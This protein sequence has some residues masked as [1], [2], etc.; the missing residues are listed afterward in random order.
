MPRAASLCGTAF[1][2]GELVL[3]VRSLF[4]QHVPSK[5]RSRGGT[6]PSAEDAVAPVPLPFAFEEHKAKVTAVFT[7]EDLGR[8]FEIDEGGRVFVDRKEREVDWEAAGGRP[9]TLLSGVLHSCEA[10]GVKGHVTYANGQGRVQGKFRNPPASSCWA[11]RATSLRAVELTVAEG[12]PPSFGKLGKLK[13]AGAAAKPGGGRPKSARPLP[14]HSARSSSSSAR[15]SSSSSSSSS[16]HSTASS[17]HHHPS[18]RPKA[19]RAGPRRSC[20]W[21][22]AQASDELNRACFS[23]RLAEEELSAVVELVAGAPSAVGGETVGRGC[24]LLRA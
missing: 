18:P 15:S 11:V 14:L 10:G 2:R 7:A 8:T 5:A 24:A 6:P 21:L 3:L 19:R 12:A 16:L 1:E 22:D 9:L 17:S 13:H 20:F 23:L 4:E